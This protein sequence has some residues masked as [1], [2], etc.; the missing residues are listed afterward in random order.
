M[1]CLLL[2]LLGEI[3]TL[4]DVDFVENLLCRWLC[5]SFFSNHLCFVLDPFILFCKCCLALLLLQVNIDFLLYI[6]VKV[7][8]KFCCCLPSFMFANLSSHT[9]RTS[10]IFIN[11]TDNFIC[12]VSMTDLFSSG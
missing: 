9:M 6:F 4:V 7:Y 5:Q 3:D 10:F 11:I 2:N 8:M 1:V 12:F